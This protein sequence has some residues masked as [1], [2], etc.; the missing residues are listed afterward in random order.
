MV[1]SSLIVV[2]FSSLFRN[3]VESCILDSSSCKKLAVQ[4]ET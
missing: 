1:I 3:G 4:I 2:G